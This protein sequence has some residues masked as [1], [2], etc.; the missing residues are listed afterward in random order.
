MVKRRFID[1]NPK[2]YIFAILTRALK[3]TNVGELAR[4]IGLNAPG[5]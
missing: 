4:N 2:V 5:P 3:V 1:I